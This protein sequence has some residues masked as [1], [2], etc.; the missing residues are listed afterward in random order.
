MPVALDLAA[1]LVAF[2]VFLIAWLLLQGYRNTFGLL[3]GKIAEETADLSIAGVHPFGWLSSGLKRI[4]HFVLYSLGLV[5]QSSA[6]AWHKLIGQLASFIHETMSLIGD[7]AEAT[8]QGLSYVTRHAIPLAV[9]AVFGP[10]A[11]VVYALRKQ[12]AHLLAQV[13]HLA[14]TATHTVTHEVTKQLVRVE[15]T[16]Q[17][18]TKTIVVATAGAVAGALPRLGRVEREL[19]GV[20]ETLKDTLRKVAPAAILAVVVA[21]LARLGLS[22]TRCSRVGKVGRSVCGMDDSLL[23]SLLTDALL[24]FSTI[25]IVELSRESQS[26]VADVTAPLAV[27]VR[28]LHNLPVVG[29]VK[30][31]A[32]LADYA[33][34]RF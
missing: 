5:V 11:S 20:D 26:F 15:K 22:W 30:A 10:L 27:F 21:S 25:S 9:N 1:I 32:A 31:S 23:E 7:L 4:D 34:G 2:C 14:A 28:E 6:W 13:A 8:E 18:R 16:V 12:L 19:K 24:I 3:L 29:G 17:V 33:A